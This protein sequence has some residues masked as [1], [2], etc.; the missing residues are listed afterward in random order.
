[1]T[2]LLA[3]CHALGRETA[4]P[5]PSFRLAALVIAQH[6]KPLSGDGAY[7]TLRTIAKKCG[8]SKSTVHRA[9][10]WLTAHGWLEITQETGF[11]QGWR[12]N[13]Y[14]LAIPHA[15]KPKRVPPIM[16]HVSD[17]TPYK[18]IFNVSKEQQAG[19]K[20]P[21]TPSATGNSAAAGYWR[22]V[23]EAVQRVGRY[24]VPDLPPEVLA[25]IRQIG[26]WS[27]ICSA[28]EFDLR[29]GGPIFQKFKAAMT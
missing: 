8:L 20:S 14:K 21:K 22:A 27:S 6:C 15:P 19:D 11:G 18:K 26:G 4:V 5:F 16:G 2:T 28:M 1:M 23:L 3:F 17:R 7:P 9:V 10:G 25:A 24:R 29:P 13:R 12:R